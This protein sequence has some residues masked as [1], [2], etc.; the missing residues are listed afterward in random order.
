MHC[1]SSWSLYYAFCRNLRLFEKKSDERITLASVLAAAY[2][3]VKDGA[4]SKR[5]ISF[6]WGF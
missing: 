5:Y 2:G 3:P 1:V 4:A 6:P